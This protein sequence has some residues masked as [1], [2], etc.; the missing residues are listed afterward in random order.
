MEVVKE[1]E[2]EE[3]TLPSS[4]DLVFGCDCTGSM[5]GYIKSAQDNIRSIVDAIQAAEKV[6]VRFGLVCY[7]DHPPQDST[8]VSKVFP[9]T[10]D[11]NTM[12]AHV[13]TMTAR[14]G[15]DGPESGKAV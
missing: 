2:E 8:Y 15:G 4:I 1:E 5:G 13:D 10:S 11:V 6:D 3:S 9:F 14:G 7:R 12:K